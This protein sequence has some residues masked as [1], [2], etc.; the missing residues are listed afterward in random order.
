[1]FSV[2]VFFGHFTLFIISIVS[3]HPNSHRLDVYFEIF[4]FPFFF[5]FSVTFSFFLPHGI[6]ATKK[7]KKPLSN[8]TSHYEGKDQV[9]CFIALNIVTYKSSIVFQPISCSCSAPAGYIISSHM[10]FNFDDSFRFFLPL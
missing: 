8:S 7:G 4:C 3:F 6:K 5:F 10:A 9:K 2:W 1:M